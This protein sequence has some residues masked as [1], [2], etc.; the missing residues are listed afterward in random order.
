MVF[1]V[2]TGLGLAL[3]TVAVK[4]PERMTPVERFGLRVIGPL[5]GVGGRLSGL[6][7]DAWVGL[8][9][10]WKAAGELDALQIEIRDLRLVVGDRI[11]L[12]AENERL[13][14]LLSLTESVPY[15]VVPARVVHRQRFPDSVFVIDR[16]TDDG[17]A[18]DQPVIA[19][20]GVVGKVLTVTPRQAKVQCIND[21]DAGLAVLVGDGRQQVEAIVASTSGATCRLRHV[22]DVLEVKVGD[23]VVTSGLDQI[24]PKGL[25]V[26][27]VLSVGDPGAVEPEIVVQT[28]VD[29]GRLEEVL[30]VL[31]VPDPAPAAP[32]SSLP[33]AGAKQAAAAGAPR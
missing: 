26:G 17:V 14:R 27:T 23:R 29:F 22:Q 30:V 5:A 19:P 12:A 13:R 15:R 25:L 24:Q 21:P 16:G 18:E 20:D 11:E 7:T 32:S 31:S 6:A 28:A 10:S 1:V 3:T 9:S 8:T 4:S 2:L 33:V